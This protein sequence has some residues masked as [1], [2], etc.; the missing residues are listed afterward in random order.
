G[1]EE[2][3]AQEHRPQH[4]GDLDDHGVVQ[5]QQ[6]GE[7]RGEHEH[8][9]G[10]DPDDLALD[11]SFVAERMDLPELYHTDMPGLWRA[12]STHGAARTLV[13]GHNPTMHQAC[14]WLAKRPHAWENHLALS[15]PPGGFALFSLSQPISG[16]PLPASAELLMFTTV[17]Q[18]ENS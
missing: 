16:T 12:L 15:L 13:V 7:R 4:R 10:E 14:T 11:G 3:D 8:A 2:R 18:L 9:A 1:A 6:P 17:D 5:A